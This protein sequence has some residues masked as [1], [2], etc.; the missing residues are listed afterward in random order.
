MLGGVSVRPITAGQV[1]TLGDEVP[2]SGVVC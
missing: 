2:L 1:I